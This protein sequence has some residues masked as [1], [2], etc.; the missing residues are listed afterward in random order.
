MIFGNVDPMASSRLQTMIDRERK[1]AKFEAKTKEKWV[2]VAP[3]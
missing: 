3:L 1:L 2:K